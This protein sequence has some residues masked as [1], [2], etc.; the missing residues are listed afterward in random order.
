MGASKY[1]G[2]LSCITVR[3]FCEQ[4]ERRAVGER[5]LPAPLPECGRSRKATPLGLPARQG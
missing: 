5:R 1:W 4:H 3:Q 2:P